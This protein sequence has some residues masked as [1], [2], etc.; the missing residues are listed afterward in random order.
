M[1]SFQLVFFFASF[2]IIIIPI[3]SMRVAP[4]PLHHPTLPPG[5]LEQIQSLR[6]ISVHCP[7]LEPPSCNFAFLEDSNPLPLLCLRFLTHDGLVNCLS[8]RE[9]PRADRFICH[10]RC[11]TGIPIPPMLHLPEEELG[12]S[13]SKLSAFT[14]PRLERALLFFPSADTS[15]LDS[16]PDRWAHFR[17]LCLDSCTYNIN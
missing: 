12:R 17:L 9:L 3:S 10:R 2:Q 4:L 8:T 11:S 6:P 15:T 16:T 14:A 5:Q 1:P 7:P 13:S